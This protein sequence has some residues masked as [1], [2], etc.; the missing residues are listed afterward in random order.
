MTNLPTA[1]RPWAVFTVLLALAALT[2][3]AQQEAPMEFFGL[4]P[5]SSSQ[6]MGD[7]T[8]FRNGILASNQ[9]MVISAENATANEVTGEIQAEGDVIV[10]D[11]SHIWRGTNA[12]YNFK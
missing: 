12:V 2:S 3:Q 5:D 7:V 11:H 10:L 8:V 6:K 1:I 4:T 9:T